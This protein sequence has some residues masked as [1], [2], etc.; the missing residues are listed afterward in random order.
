LPPSI[1]SAVKPALA[2]LPPRI[3][4]RKKAEMDEMIG[5][6]KGL[7]NSILGPRA[8][9]EAPLT[10]AGKFGLSTDNFQVRLHC[11]RRR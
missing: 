3:E 8:T 7:G 5:K 9:A 6:L 10:R 4:E 2:R 11:S 1:R